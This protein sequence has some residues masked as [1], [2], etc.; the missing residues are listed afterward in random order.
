MAHKSRFDTLENKNLLIYSLIGVVVI[1]LIAHLTNQEEFPIT[2]G[3]YMTDLLFIIFPVAVIIF[4]SILVVRYGLH[5][6]HGIAW[7]LFTLAF[8]SWFAGELT[9]NY[10]YEYDIEDLSTLTSDIFYILGYPLFL[11][12]TIFYLRPRKKIISKKLIVVSSLVSLLFVV[13]T[14]YLTFGIEYEYLDAL[15]VFLYA[16]YPILD[17]IIL[18][19]SI[20]AVVLFFRGQVNLL[21]IMILLGTIVEIIA[22]LGY[23]TFS[24]EETYYPGH[25]INIL[26]ISTYVLFAFGALSHIRLYK[27]TSRFNLF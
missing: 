18:I 16:I 17:A 3:W 21:W 14:L 15:T 25:P 13:P 12:F 4:G 7:L 6:N 19:P 22:G 10:E 24:I 11:G 1:F 23:L 9:Y 8:C 20:I 5:G 26:F 2:E 27:K